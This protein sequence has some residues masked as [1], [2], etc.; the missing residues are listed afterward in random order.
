MRDDKGMV[1]RM[2]GEPVGRLVEPLLNG[3]VLCGL[4]ALGEH[5]LELALE[6]LAHLEDLNERLLLYPGQ[7]FVP[8]SL[9]QGSARM[10]EASQ[11]VKQAVELIK[12]EGLQ[13]EPLLVAAFGGGEVFRRGVGGGRWPG[14]GDGGQRRGR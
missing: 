7:I 11:A 9:D 3:G 10:E 6:P 1:G 2:S 4:L 8:G 13:E 5:A 14:D 12:A